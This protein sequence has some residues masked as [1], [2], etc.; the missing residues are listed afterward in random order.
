[1]S[2]LESVNTPMVAS[3]TVTALQAVT[4]ATLEAACA[5]CPEY[6]LLHKLIE[7][8][9]P[10]SSK[11]WEQSLLPYYRHRHALSTIGPVVLVHDRPVVP[12]SLRTRVMDHIHAGH[13]GLSTMCQRLSR[14]LYWPNY[15]DDLTK[16]KLNCSTCLKIAPSNPAMPPR[17]PV[18]PQYPFQSVVCDF[19]AM[20][21]H[22]YVALADR[23][24]NWV[25]VFKLKQ[26]TS[27]ELIGILRGYFATFGVPEIFSSDGASIFTSSL[28]KD[29]CKRW[30]IEQRIS[31]AYHARSNKRAEVAVTSKAP[32]TRQSWSCWHIKHRLPGQSS[33]GP[34]QHT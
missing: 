28:F 16:A 20:A 32:R 15:R 4:W 33:P 2:N 8:G 23:Y 5:A 12:K 30:G 34:A 11:D 6:L 10:E 31:S 22:T 17:P 9:V 1:M 25:S 21:G 14:S 27:A 26:D 19:F 3:M 24:S 29:F 13:P 7:Q 18:A